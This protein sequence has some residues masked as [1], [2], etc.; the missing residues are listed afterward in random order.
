MRKKLLAAVFAATAALCGAFGL[1]ACL[2]KPDNGND[3]GKDEVKHTHD[4]GTQLVTDKDHHWH[5]CNNDGCD[6]KII[7]KAEHNDTDSDGKCD[8]CEYQISEVV[9]SEH[10]LIPV[11]ETVA[12]CTVNGNIAYYICGDCG[13]WFTDKD[14]QNEIIDKSSVVTFKELISVTENPATCTTEGNKAYYVCDECGKW[15]SDKGGKYEVKDK[16]SVILPKGHRVTQVKAK[17]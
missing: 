8:I 3:D 13:K 14:G 9:T 17:E 15:Y 16:T 4:Y 11:A 12:T 10:K 7:D 1:S 5:E 2:D 6:E